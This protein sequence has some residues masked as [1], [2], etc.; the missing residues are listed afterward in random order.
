M[1]MCIEMIKDSYGN[2]SDDGDER[3]EIPHRK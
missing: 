1:I 2:N 3:S